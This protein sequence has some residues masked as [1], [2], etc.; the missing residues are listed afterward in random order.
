MDQ[1]KRE[2]RKLKVKIK[3]AGNKRRR[4]HLKRELADDPAEAHH[5]DDFDYGRTSSSSLNGM[6]QD[7]TRR[8]KD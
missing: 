5:D 4:Q 8:Q 6:D 7:S 3:K 2:L 1:H